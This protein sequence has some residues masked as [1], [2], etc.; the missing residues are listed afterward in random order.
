MSRVPHNTFV[1][2]RAILTFIC[3]R[4]YNGQWATEALLPTSKSGGIKSADGH[5]MQ[6]QIPRTVAWSGRFE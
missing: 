5:V 6:H 4:N 3:D 1:K 2:V